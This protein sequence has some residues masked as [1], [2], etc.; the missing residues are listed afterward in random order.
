[1]SSVDASPFDLP[2][3]GPA[4][5]LCLHGL[6]GTPYEV[7][8]LGEALSRAGIRAFGPALPGHNSTPEKLAAVRWEEWAEAARA[9]AAELRSQHDVVFGVGLSMGGLLTLLVAAEGQYDAAAAIGVPL[10]LG[11]PVRLLVPALRHLVR[12]SPKPRGS[13]IRDAEA[14]RRHPSYDVMPLGAVAELMQLQRRVRRLLPRVQAPL[15]VAHGAH[16]ATANPADSR[17]ILDAVG[18]EDRRHLVLPD[19]GHVVPVDRDGE[20]L[21]GEVA[22]FLGSRVAETPADALTAPHSRS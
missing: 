6:T 12:F 7:R 21:A 9:S 17:E 5:A 3:A 15:L 14:R 2:G 18:S 1:M 13:D 4:A 22:G 16:D 10:R 8:P 19:S 20:R 11:W